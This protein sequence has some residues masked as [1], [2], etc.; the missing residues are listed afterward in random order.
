[1]PSCEKCWEDAGGNYEKYTQLIEER[2]DD[3]CSFEE[4][5]GREAAICEKCN[6]KTVHQHAKVCIACGFISE[7][8][9]DK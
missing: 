8:D 3:P 9:S 7:I 1:M 5:A 2:K 6:R 4:Q